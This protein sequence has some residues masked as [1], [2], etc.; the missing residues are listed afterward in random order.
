MTT[1]SNALEERL[2]P[3]RVAA[4]YM[5]ALAARIDLVVMQTSREWQRA[6]SDTLR[7]A[8]DLLEGAP[9]DADAYQRALAC[10]RVMR[11]G[12]DPVCHARRMALEAVE[13]LLERGARLL[14]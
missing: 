3:P 9:G 8:A 10:L 13:D 7:L 14:C 2:A 6:Y 12:L 5:R 1:D 4:E 11:L